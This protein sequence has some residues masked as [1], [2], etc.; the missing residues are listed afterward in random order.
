MFEFFVMAVH[1]LSQRKLRSS[2]TVLGIVIGIAAI[3]S[4]VSIGEGM[5]LMVTEQLRGFGANKIMVLPSMQMGMGTSIGGLYLTER[6]LDDIKDTRGVDI[7]TGMLV[8]T[9]SVDY[10]DEVA[11]LTVTGIEPEDAEKFFADVQGFEIETGRWMDTDEKYSVVIGNI[12]AYNLFSEDVRLKDKL[13]IK[14][15]TVKVVGI[16]KEIG[17]Y[18]DDTMVVISLETLRNIVEEEE[19]ITMILVKVKNVEEV[20]EVAEDI[21]EDL[22]KTYGEK[23][24]TVMTA[25]QIV[26]QVGSIIGIISVFLGGVAAISLLVAG[27]GIANTMF[28]SIMERTREIGIMKAIGATNRTVLVMFLTESVLIGLIGG[29]IGCTIGI[30]MSKV[31]DRFSSFYG[32][33]VKTAVTLELLFIGLIFSMVVG[34]ISG[35][36]PARKAAKLQ[37]VEALRYE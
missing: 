4:L 32:I 13:E 15:T 2:L 10:K 22:E 14:D 23:M 21:E 27:I 33:Q 5:R 30:G 18:Q 12:A 37:P 20:E 24:F 16:M 3:V 1:N 17:N 34:I 9:L 7:A 35:F 36:L 26:E 19:E 8:K 11:A 28:M 25:Q 29:A 31:I 6:D